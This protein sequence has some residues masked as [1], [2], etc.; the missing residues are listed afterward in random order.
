[1]AAWH[2]PHHVAETS[3]MTTLPRKSESLTVAAFALTT[4]NSGARSPWWRKRATVST[5]LSPWTG[6]DAGLCP[7]DRDTDASSKAEPRMN[8][9]EERIIREGMEGKGK[10]RPARDWAGR[11]KTIRTAPRE[12]TRRR[13]PG[14]AGCECRR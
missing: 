12:R 14:R 1:M 3:T 5:G 8:E 11:T 13:D 10:I 7:C 6:T 2:G 4:E 9:V